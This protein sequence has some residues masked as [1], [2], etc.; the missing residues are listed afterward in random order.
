VTPTTDTVP[1]T[2]TA[3][4]IFG[5]FA[6]IGSIS[7][8]GGA[9]GYLRHALVVQK[10]WLDEEEFLSG[11]ELAQTLPGLNAVNMGVYVGERLCGVRG[12]LAATLGMVLPGLALVLGLGASYAALAGKAPQVLAAL[13]GVA[14][15]ATGFLLS[16]ALKTG[17]KQLLHWKPLLFVVATFT[18]M[19][20]L[21]LPLV[22]IVLVLGGLAVWLNRPGHDGF[23][24]PELARAEP[25]SEP[26]TEPGGDAP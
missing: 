24:P 12:A 25:A 8:G 15:A 3:T 6:K 9:I 26:L 21:R 13:H 19:S 17:R 1:V 4:E 23:E 5:V 16:V 22:G 10:R 18:A 11:L 7:F 14:A 20:I 2:A